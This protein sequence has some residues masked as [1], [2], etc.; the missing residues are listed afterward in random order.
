MT[1]ERAVV[2]TIIEVGP[3]PEYGAS[4]RFYPRAAGAR[5]AAE[6]LAGAA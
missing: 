4:L 3:D 6:L 5:T 1:V 2:A